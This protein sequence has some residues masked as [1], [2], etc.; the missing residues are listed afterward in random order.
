MKTS[1]P[2]QFDTPSTAAWQID[3]IASTVDFA[4]EE[5]MAFVKRRT[6]TGCFA[7]VA[8][9]IA[10]DRHHP[11]T[12]QVE[13]AIDARTVDTG[14]ARRD[15]NL[16]GKHFFD[17]ASCPTITFASRWCDLADASAGRYRATGYLTVRGITR[18]IAIEAEGTLSAS[19]ARIA[20]TFVLDRRD[21]GMTRGNPFLWI[22]D[23]V[24]ISVAL[25]AKAI[26]AAKAA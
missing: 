3:P 1:V 7:G 26:A 21:F 20:A 2:L 10:L 14:D 19:F 23:D 25:E 9:T 17:T 11:A 15:K 5:R 16:R 12:S 13:I 24:R 22:A 4:I 6:V 8:G 18:E